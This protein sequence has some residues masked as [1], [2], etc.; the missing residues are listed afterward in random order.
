MEAK[1]N[2][3]DESVCNKYLAKAAELFTSEC[4][5]GIFLTLLFHCCDCIFSLLLLAIFLL[6]MCTV[7]HCTSILHGVM[8]PFVW[9]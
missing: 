2:S 4:M 5:T 3:S 6:N 9:Q 7:H 8:L 1:G